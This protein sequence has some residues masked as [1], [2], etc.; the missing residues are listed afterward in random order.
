[1]K[2]ATE[3]VPPGETCPVC[4]GGFE[5]GERGLAFKARGTSRWQHIHVGC[6]EGNVTRDDL[7]A[8][9]RRGLRRVALRT[10]KP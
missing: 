7:L 6:V 3:P 1:M 2:Y 5:P 9:I 4:E 10:A 8:R